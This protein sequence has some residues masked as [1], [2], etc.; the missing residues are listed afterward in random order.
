M[1]F[2]KIIR[3]YNEK[4][5]SD[6]HNLMMHHGNMIVFICRRYFTRSILFDASLMAVG[7][8]LVTHVWLSSTSNVALWPGGSRYLVVLLWL[9]LVQVWTD[10]ARASQATFNLASHGKSIYSI[11]SS[12]WDFTWYTC[13]SNLCFFD[14]FIAAWIRS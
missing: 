13:K 7:I 3:L 14:K 10:A 8:W 9:H 11:T 5:W 4:L 1:A 6:D 2:I 12:W